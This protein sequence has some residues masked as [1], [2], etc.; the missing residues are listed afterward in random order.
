MLAGVFS[1]LY[2][3]V[4][5]IWIIYSYA[6]GVSASLMDQYTSN[7]RHHRHWYLIILAHKASWSI[8]LNFCPGCVCFV[9]S[10]VS[11]RVNRIRWW[12]WTLAGL[13]LDLDEFTLRDTLKRVN[14][15]YE[16]LLSCS[17]I[18]FSTYEICVSVLVLFGYSLIFKSNLLSNLSIRA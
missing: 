1:L 18:F 8:I 15:S 7:R 12:Y 5:A 11:L 9:I 4:I 10:S 13:Q 3:R 17:S 14:H 16:K 2:I 6:L